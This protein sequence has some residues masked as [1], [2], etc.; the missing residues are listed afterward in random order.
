[1]STVEIT[2]KTADEAKKVLSRSIDKKVW[3]RENRP[4]QIANLDKFQSM[5]DAEMSA[6]EELRVALL[7]ED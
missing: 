2:E 1:M 4:D 6:F 7:G 5:L 3:M